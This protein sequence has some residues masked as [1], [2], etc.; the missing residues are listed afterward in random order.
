[1]TYRM[2]I[3]KYSQYIPEIYLLVSVL[4]YWSLTHSTINPYAIGLILIIAFQIFFRVKSTG[5]LISAIFIGL[6]FFL[7]L[8][9]MSELSEF[10]EFNSK[11]K[12]MAF[13]GFGY[14][15]LNITI[16]SWMFVKYLSKQ[17]NY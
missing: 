8:A 5:I 9:L 1:M 15:I 11:A 10:P 4:Y 2:K 7:I 12:K 17:S 3:K 13:V 6:N 14:L 16:G